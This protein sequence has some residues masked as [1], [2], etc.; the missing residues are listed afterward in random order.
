[1]TFNVLAQCYVR[2]SFFPYCDSK[3]LRWKARS[4]LLVSTL[5]MFFDIYIYELVD[6]IQKREIEAIQP[7]PDVVCLQVSSRTRYAIDIYQSSGMR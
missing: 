4:E 5:V 1:M 3:A 2:S 6:P 7:R